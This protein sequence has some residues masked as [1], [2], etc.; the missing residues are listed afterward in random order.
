MTLRIPPPFVPQGLF[1][2]GLVA[3]ARACADAR[4]LRAR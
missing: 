4:L 2:L 3:K 1:C